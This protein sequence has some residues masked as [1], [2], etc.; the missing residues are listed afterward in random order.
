MQDEEQKYESQTRGTIQKRYQDVV[1][2]PNIVLS[3]YSQD[4]SLR[5][6]NYYHPLVEAINQSNILPA[7]L[8]FT[9]QEIALTAEMVDFHFAEIT[10]LSQYIDQHMDHTQADD[11]LLPYVFLSRA[12]EFAIVQDYSSAI[13]DCTR[14]LQCPLA[15][16]RLHVIATFCRANWRYRLLEYQRATGE[17]DATANM[18]FDIMLRDYDQVIRIQPD[19][20]FAIFNKANILCAQKQWNDAIDYYTQAIQLD[21][22]FAEAWFNRGLTYV[23]IGE[24]EKGM[25]DLSKAGELGIYQAYNMIS[26]FK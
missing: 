25:T 26:R 6:T 22:D 17:Q 4:L 2:E 20:A 5:R 16:N 8:R 7:T 10:R 23:Y 9:G 19:F 15:D 14:A 21:G 13:D 1:N 3:Y 11:N 24:N 18:D 12:V